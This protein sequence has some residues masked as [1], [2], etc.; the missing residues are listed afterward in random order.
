[1]QSDNEAVRLQKFLAN[2]GITSRRA[3]EDL[4]LRGAVKV[5]GRIAVLGQKVT[6]DDAIA[7]NG[8]LISAKQM[9]TPRRVLIY[10]KPIG[11]I[12]TRSDPQNRPTVFAKLPRLQNGRWI[13]IG[14][15]DVNTSGLLLFTTCGALAN[16]LMH[17]SANIDREY[18]VRI[19]GRA[20]DKQI[21]NLLAG[22]MLEGESEPMRFTDIKAAPQGD[23]ANHWYH[24]VVMEG[25]NREVRKL[26]QSQDLSVSRLKRV[27][28]G[29]VFLT[30]ELKVGQF[31][32]MTEKE[33]EVLCREV[34][35]TA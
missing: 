1:M 9:Q 6:A 29:P 16:H 7:V 13:S 11:E 33:L 5:N 17:P 27:R 31:R 19:F 20:S 24:C 10:N 18:A 8:K 2:A 22:V 4:I 15:L 25:R 35:F 30:S 34:G 32:E 3:A 14:R 12:C 21:A 23:G 26:W 28:F